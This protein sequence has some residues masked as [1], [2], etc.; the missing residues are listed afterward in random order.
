MAARKLKP[1]H[2]EEVKAK[3]QTSQLVNFLQAHALKGEESKIDP[4]RIKAAEILLARSLPTLSAVEQTSINPDDKLDDSALLER[5]KALI[6]ANPDLLQIVTQSS[7]NA[8][9]APCADAQTE[10]KT[11]TH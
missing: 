10:G 7:N 1:H 9:I 2:Q 5:F 3:I 4:T 8:P 11:I 6:A